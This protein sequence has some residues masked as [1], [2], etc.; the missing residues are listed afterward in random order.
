MRGDGTLN[1]KVFQ[2]SIFR[3]LLA[4]VILSMKTKEQTN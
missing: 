1:I 2:K 3:N 4:S